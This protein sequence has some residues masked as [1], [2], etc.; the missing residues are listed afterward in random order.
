MNIAGWLTLITTEAFFAGVLPRLCP[1]PSPLTNLGLIA[2][3]LSAAAV[4]GSKG[5][6]Q[7]TEWNTYLIFLA[8]STFSTALNIFGYRILGVWNEGAC[9]FPAAIQKCPSVV[10]DRFWSMLVHPGLHSHKH[11]HFS[12][13]HQ[14]RRRLRFH[15]AHQ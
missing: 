9:E 14:N 7:I 2:Q 6:Y 8:V 13:F 1:C 15:D 3:F 5:T 12:H 4:I 10:A 11:Y